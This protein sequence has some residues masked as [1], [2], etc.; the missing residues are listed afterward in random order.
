MENII[1][2]IDKLT[3]D[4]ENL[5]KACDKQLLNREIISRSFD[6]SSSDPRK[7]IIDCC[8]DQIITGFIGDE[9]YKYIFPPIIEY[10]NKDKKILRLNP[11]GLGDIV[12]DWRSMEQLWRHTFDKLRVL[13]EDN[14]VILTEPPNNSKENR[15]KM[16]KIMFDTFNVP[17]LCIINKAYLTLLASG[18]KTGVVVHSDNNNT[19]YIVPIYE[20]TVINHSV[21]RISFA[22]KDLTQYMM[23]MLNNK[24]YNFTSNSNYSIA[25]DIKNKLCYVA[26]DFEDEIKYYDYYY[27]DKK[28]ELPDGNIININIESFRCPEV[29]FRPSLLAYDSIGIHQLTYNS[30]MKCNINIQN[31]LFGNIVL[32][33]KTMNLPGFNKRM[34]KELTILAPRSRINIITQSD[35]NFAEWKATSNVLSSL[36][37]KHYISKAEYVESGP[38]IVHRKCW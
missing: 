22:G 32:S 20:G 13:P 24:G 11:I 27:L 8:S 19:T 2:K 25:D 31:E 3:V 26:Y 34:H 17:A 18:K 23:K 15:E 6:P 4:I 35:D 7:I 36:E 37:L 16:T 12:T 10:L 21:E 14:I 9:K 33:G 1:T 30:I 5:I 28:Y 29:M 38:S